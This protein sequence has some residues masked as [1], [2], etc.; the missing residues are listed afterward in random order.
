METDVSWLR[1]K[2]GGAAPAPDLGALE[3]SAATR[4]AQ[5]NAQRAEVAA[6]SRDVDTVHS[7]TQRLRQRNRW[8]ALIED[9]MDGKT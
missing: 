3:A 5:A 8:A 6:R 9:V 1:R 7:Q 2:R 4:L